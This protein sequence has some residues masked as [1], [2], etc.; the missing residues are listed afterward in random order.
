MLPFEAILIS[1]SVV[2]TEL[3][4]LISASYKIGLDRHIKLADQASWS[5]KL[6]CLRFYLYAHLGLKSEAKACLTS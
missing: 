3:N 6:C 5:F 1:K 4:K 2:V